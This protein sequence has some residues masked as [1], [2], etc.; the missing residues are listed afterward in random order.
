MK[1]HKFTHTTITHHE[2]GSHTTK[3]HHED[4]KS[5]KEYAKH[6]L[7]RK[8]DLASFRLGQTWCP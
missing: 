2:D 7:L 1:H 4:G 5:H 3:H 6:E 8:P